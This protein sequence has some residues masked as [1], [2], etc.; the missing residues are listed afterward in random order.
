MTPE[1][2][3]FQ[4]WHDLLIGLTVDQA[5]ELLAHKHGFVCV[6]KHDGYPNAMFIRTAEYRLDR[7]NVSVNKYNVINDYHGRG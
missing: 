7:H 5:D 3:D 6:N 2:H 4:H 1:E